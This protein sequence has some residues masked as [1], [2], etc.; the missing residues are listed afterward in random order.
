MH[1]LE[2]EKDL[3]FRKLKKEKQIKSKI[4]KGV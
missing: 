1:I 2:K 4:S 3:D